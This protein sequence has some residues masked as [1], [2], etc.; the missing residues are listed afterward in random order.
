MNST[1]S[2]S[3]SADQ[4]AADHLHGA[5]AEVGAPASAADGGL[6]ASRKRKTLQDRIEVDKLDITL[7]EDSLH[8]ADKKQTKG[9]EKAASMRR[10]GRRGGTI[11]ALTGAVMGAIPWQRS[12]FDCNEKLP[13]N[14]TKRTGPSLSFVAAVKTAFPRVTLGKSAAESQVAA[15]D[16]A[17]FMKS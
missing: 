12:D 5:F 14:N 3:R 2:V 4:T 9:L 7:P 8:A 15:I 10:T 6:P 13:K 17:E 16:I 11:E 1:T